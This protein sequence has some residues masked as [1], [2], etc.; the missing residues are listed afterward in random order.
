MG[1]PVM[2]IWT[3]INSGYKAWEFQLY[4]YGLAPGLLYG[5]L[6]FK[7]WQNFCKLAYAMRIFNQHKIP[8]QDLQNAHKSMMEFVSEFEE[9]YYQRQARRLH[10]VQPFLHALAHTGPEVVRVGPPIC[11]SQWTLERTIGNLGQ[12]I[13]Q[14]SNPYMNL[15]YRALRRAQINALK[16]TIPDLEPLVNQ[17]PRGAKDLGGGYALL[18]ALE[19]SPHRIR[20]CEARVIRGYLDPDCDLDEDIFLAKW[21]RL[22]LPTGQAAHSEWREGVTKRLFPYLI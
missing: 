9:L 10:F 3:K 7:Y 6:P 16:I 13:R 14:P 20:N 15:S 2:P 12:E 8:T 4:L 18:R 5:I 22:R 21:A 1:I 17:L 19:R 11:S